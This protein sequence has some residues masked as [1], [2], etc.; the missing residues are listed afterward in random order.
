MPKLSI[1][2]DYDRCFNQQK[3]SVYCVVDV[4]IR[5]NVTLA[6]WRYIEVMPLD[7]N[8]LDSLLNFHKFQMFSS[9]KKHHFRHDRLQRGICMDRCRSFVPD[10]DIKIYQN[11]STKV[12]LCKTKLKC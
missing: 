10:F 8:L 2:D 11:D 6:L 7:M 5:P 1:Y 12:C 9:D 3:V 4:K